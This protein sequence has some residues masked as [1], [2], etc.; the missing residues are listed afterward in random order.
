M[1]AAAA[2]EREHDGRDGRDDGWSGL[3]GRLRSSVPLAG[4]LATAAMGG[5]ALSQATGTSWIPLV[6]SLQAFTP[7]LLAPAVPALVVSAVRRRWAAAGVHAG[8]SLCL[9]VL[10]LPVLRHPSPPAVAADAPALTIAHANVYFRNERPAALVEV[11]L[12]TGADVIAMSEYSPAVDEAFTAA[13]GLDR[14]PYGLS[15]VPGDRDGMALFSR[16]PLVSQ[17]IGRLTSGSF[18]DVVLDVQGVEVRMVVVHPLPGTSR[19]ALSAWR[20]DL[21]AIG[22]LVADDAAAGGSPA[23]VVGDFNA[24]RWHPALRDLLD[25]GW[26]DAHEMLGQGFS[27]SWPTDRRFPPLVRIDRALVN[28][29]ISPRSTVDVSLPGSDHAG[30]VLDLAVVD[31]PTG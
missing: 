7:W 29:L 14:Y 19:E 6:W 18:I 24:T 21:D 13:G 9:V 12:A 1:T 28:D 20:D 5:L 10:V 22:H 31:L 30:F 4:W 25:D 17:E 26:S 2:R 23:V 3:A 11:L 8:I 15:R 16:F 27:R